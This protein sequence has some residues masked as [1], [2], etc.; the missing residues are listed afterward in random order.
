MGKGRDK[1]R[2]KARNNEGILVRKPD[3]ARDPFSGWDDPDALVAAPLRPRPHLRSGAVALPQPRQP[4]EQHVRFPET[5][6]IG[7]GYFDLY[8]ASR[9]ERREA[10]V[11]PVSTLPAGVNLNISMWSLSKKPTSQRLRP[12]R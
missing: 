8:C 5:E 11:T 10:T 4:D 3:P 7:S 9:S 12:N 6:A 1:R 2:R